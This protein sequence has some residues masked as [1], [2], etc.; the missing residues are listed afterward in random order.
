MP[1]VTPTHPVLTW[2]VGDITVT[3][4]TEMEV[5]WP[6]SA[7]LPG[8]DD[9]IGS[10]DWLTPD[11]V[12]DS[13]RMRLS[14]HSLVVRT[15][16]R[17][18]VVDTCVGNDKKLPGAP[19][20]NE[21]STDFGAQMAAAGHP[22]ES[23]DTVVCTHLH[24]D[25]VGWNTTLVDGVWV[26]TFPDARY[27]MVR[28]EYDHW[29]SEPQEYGP[30]F[31]QSI[32]PVVDAGLVDLVEPDHQLA[33]GVQLESTPG[34][35]PGHVSVAL[36]SGDQRAVI[37]GDMTHHPVQFA[38][39]D[40]ASSADVDQQAST[41]TRWSAYRRWSDGRLVI[42]THFAGRTAGHLIAD[43]DAWRFS[44]VD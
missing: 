25:H 16:D 43:G 27:V 37:T 6:F 29:R 1:S 8:A 35:T 28:A 24:V 4:V 34:H 9:L 38:H 42:G 31:S 11:F 14:I 17:T 39:P 13:G 7:L 36:T 32:E 12:A 3:K 40:L 26:P 30:V 44:P 21:R 33:D 2:Q 10:H 22:K 15:G 5:H 41:A 20:F 23:V 19:P 18:I